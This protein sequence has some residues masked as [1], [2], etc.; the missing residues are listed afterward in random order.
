NF[1]GF[2]E[3]NRFAL[4]WPTRVEEKF[5]FSLNPLVSITG[6]IDRIDVGPDGQALVIDYKYS[7]GN[8]IRERVEDTGEGHLVQGGLYLAAAERAFGLDPVAMLFCGLKKDVT[9][10]GWHVSIPGLESLGTSS[11]R[12]FIRALIDDAEK[13][14][15]RVHEAITSGDIAVRPANPDKCRW[16][17]F[18]DICRVES[19]ALMQVAT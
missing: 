18:C 8:K 16:C 11:T 12:E 7:A 5:S 2:L 6:R 9:W 10:D 15:I 19:A 1:R 14:A 17:D 4:G 3:D 13:A